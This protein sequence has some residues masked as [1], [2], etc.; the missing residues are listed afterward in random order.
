MAHNVEIPSTLKAGDTVTF[1][2]YPQ[3]SDSPQ[4]IEWRVLS[5]DGHRALIVSRYALDQALYH[6]EYEDVTWSSCTLRRLLNGEFLEAAFTPAEQ[7]RIL[8]VTLSNPDNPV[9]GTPGGCNTE[10]RIFCLST[11]EA[12]QYFSDNDD[13]ICHPTKRAADKGIWMDYDGD[14]WWW[15]RS[16]G[17]PRFSAVCVY[18]DGDI[19]IY[20]DTVSIDR[21]CIRPA[22]YL[23]LLD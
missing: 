18:G 13:R 10:D 17:K 1:G 22:L 15:L 6:E 23:N 9:F 2:S 5:A 14:C 12:E 7:R 8:S 20:G 19:N 4:P 21:M 11:Q 16:P 3:N